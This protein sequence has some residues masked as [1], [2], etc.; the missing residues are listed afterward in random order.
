MKNNCGLNGANSP[1]RNG[2]WER[3]GGG[4]MTEL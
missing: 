4:G 1:L 2:L 3:E